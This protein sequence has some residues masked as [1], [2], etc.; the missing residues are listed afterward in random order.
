MTNK[1]AIKVLCGMLQTERKSEELLAISLAIAALV[2][3]EPKETI[4][5][6][7]WVWKQN[8]VPLTSNDFTVGE[9]GLPKY[10]EGCFNNPKNG[11]SG[12]CHCI[13]GTPEVR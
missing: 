1:E 7:K 8:D 4:T 6:S 9:Y 3:T 12:I 13:L 5:T 2:E 10:C 11:G